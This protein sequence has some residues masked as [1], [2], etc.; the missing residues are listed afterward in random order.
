MTIKKICYVLFITFFIFSCKNKYEKFTEKPD[1][2]VNPSAERKA[3]FEAYDATLKVW[4]VPFKEL[5]IPTTFGTA[6]V[7]VSGPDSGE[8]LVLFHGMNSSSTMW[9]PNIKALNADYQVFAIDFIL[10]PGKSFKTK[11]IESTEQIAAWYQEVISKL[12]LKSYHLAGASR[13]GWLAVNLALQNQ[14]KIKSMILLSP[15]QTFIWIRPSA[16]LLKNIIYA[17]SSKDKQIQKSLES[18]SNDV[19]NINKKYIEQ[20]AIG[21]ELDSTNK[22]VVDMMPFSKVDFQSLKMPV[23]VMI[24]DNDVINNTKSLKIAEKYIANNQTEEISNAGHF[25]SVDQAE[26]VN[27]KILEFLNNIKK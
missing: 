4:D 23:L 1:Y 16:D 13:G 6:H 22:F 7:V 12:E 17:F 26:V 8:P 5:Y 2:I 10:E 9:Y 11:E 3:Y 21:R 24:G 27:N 14:D 25:L 19:S 18:M 15:A 20:Y